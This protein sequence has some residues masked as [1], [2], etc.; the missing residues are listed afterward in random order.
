M[1]MLFQKKKAKKT[2][3][4][5]PRQIHVAYKINCVS[6]ISDILCTFEV[7]LKVFFS[8]KDES[9]VGRKEGSSVNY[10]LEKGGLMDQ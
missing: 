1:F 7:D 8:W 3:D 4:G 9:L 5:Q 10:A 6:D 2:S